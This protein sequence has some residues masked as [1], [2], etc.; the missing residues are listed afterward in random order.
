MKK[1]NLSIFEY[2]RGVVFW[3]LVLTLRHF[4][5]GGEVQLL[6]L[7][8]LSSLSPFLCGGIIAQIILRNTSFYT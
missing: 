8:I 3:G 6:A 5:G 1:I 7:F 4:W 2:E